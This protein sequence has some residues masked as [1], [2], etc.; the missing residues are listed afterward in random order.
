MKGNKELKPEVEPIEL[1]LP[2]P[3]GH[4]TLQLR[5]CDWLPAPEPL[6]ILLWGGTGR[7]S[8]TF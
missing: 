7:G 3:P 4:N 1:C 2:L 8:E 6:G 5:A